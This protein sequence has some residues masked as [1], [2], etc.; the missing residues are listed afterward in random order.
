MKE[1]INKVIEFMRVGD[2][3][4]QDTVQDEIPDN[5]IAMSMK[6]LKEEVAELEEAF[7]IIED[8][9][10][11]KGDPIDNLIN[12]SDDGF[13]TVKDRPTDKVEVLDA[14][15]DI[16][17][18]TYGIYARMGMQHVAQKAF[19]EVHR[20]NMTKVVDGN[21][22]K[23]DSGKIIKPPTYSPPNL[24]QFTHAEVSS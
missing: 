16:L 14:L 3:Y 19:D 23:D 13:V 17:Y 6:L 15:T 7:G 1:N 11:D 18:V 5:E 4:V 24:Y 22:L 21:F 10:L 2:Q 20:S 12:Q 8:L 9:M